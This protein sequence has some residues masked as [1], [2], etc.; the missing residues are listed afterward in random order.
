MKKIAWMAL[1]SIGILILVSSLTSFEIQQVFKHKSQTID[2]KSGD[3]IFQS[4]STGQSLAVQLATHSKY[5]HCGVVFQEGSKWFVYEAVQPVR[6][7]L[8]SDWIQQGD[9]EHFVTRRLK[10]ESILT[11]ENLAKMKA[12]YTNFAGRDYD[13]YFAWTDDE[14]YCSELVWKMY[15]IGT[16]LKVGELKK[17]KS[18]DL[19][20][21][22]VKAIMKQRYGSNL[23]LEETVISPESIFDSP[24]LETILTK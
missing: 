18:F 1:G 21:S 12:V 13:I 14:L 16:G 11:K 3:I 6:K 19:T 9:D 23:P 5:S 10:E 2:L 15:Q 20:S 24:L 17:F 7:T 22:E 4:S 8:F